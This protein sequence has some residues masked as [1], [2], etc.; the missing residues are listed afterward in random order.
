METVGDLL[1]IG[2]ADPSRALRFFRLTPPFRPTE[3]AR[4]DARPLIGERAADRMRVDGN[5]RNWGVFQVQDLL[6]RGGTVHAAF[7]GYVLGADFSDPARP[8]VRYVFSPADLAPDDFIEGI[9]VT[10]DRLFLATSDRGAPNQWGRSNRLARRG[11]HGVTAYQLDASPPARLVNYAGVDM[12]ERLLADRDV[13]YV[14]GWMLNPRSGVS[15]NGIVIRPEDSGERLERRLCVTAVDISDPGDMRELARIEFPPEFHV[16]G[17]MRV[18]ACRKMILENNLLYVADHAY[19]LRIL[20]VGDRASIRQLGHVRTVVGESNGVVLHGDRALLE[21][22]HG[23]VPIH[24][25]KTPPARRPL[26]RPALHAPSS[27]PSTSPSDSPSRDAATPDAE[28]SRIELD[29]FLRLP[30]SPVNLTLDPASPPVLFGSVLRLGNLLAAWEWSDPAPR[31]AGIQ[32]LPD[33][34]IARRV[35]MADG[36]VYILAVSDRAREVRILVFRPGGADSSTLRPVADIPLLRLRKALGTWASLLF[37]AQDRRAIAVI[38]GVG[39]SGE[40]Q[41]VLVGADLREEA[42]PV[43]LGPALVRDVIPGNWNTSSP[44]FDGAHL[45]IIGGEDNDP[46]VYV[47]D[48]GDFT[49]PRVVGETGEPDRRWYGDLVS[50]PSRKALLV[51]EYFHGI[52][53]VDVADPTAPRITWRETPAPVD[54]IYR[55]LGWSVGAVRGDRVYSPRLDRLRVFEF[56]DD[57]VVADTAP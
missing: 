56:A 5:F 7:A 40:P 23:L 6:I 26:R 30:P 24:L 37:W 2:H 12:P 51:Q 14:A 44:F 48:A 27:A 47:V 8:K 29:R 32:R 54:D 45:F 4:I 17:Q 21:C 20:D 31:L 11:R 15:V 33:G 9:A 10:N 34:R 53:I 46:R 57:S 43:R 22:H 42:R 36:L 19:G 35:V 38:R 39:E 50:V 16:G 52:R 3:L 1:I 28:S 49:S 41:M 55:T 18:A 25:S 13:L